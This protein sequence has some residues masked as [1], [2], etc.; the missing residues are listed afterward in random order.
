MLASPHIKYFA[1]IL[2]PANPE[3]EDKEKQR[4]RQRII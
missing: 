3:I 4:Q 2:V 1:V